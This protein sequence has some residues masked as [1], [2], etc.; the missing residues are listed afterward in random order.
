MSKQSQQQGGRR[1]GAQNQKSVQSSANDQ[2]YDG[3]DLLDSL[4][5]GFKA[6]IDDAAAQGRT[7]IGSVYINEEAFNELVYDHLESLNEANVGNE[8]EGESGDDNSN[9][10]DEEGSYK[11]VDASMN[12]NQGDNFTITQIYGY[13]GTLLAFKEGRSPTSQQMICK[14]ME[15]AEHRPLVKESKIVMIKNSLPFD[16]NFKL[17]GIRSTNV[18]MDQ[19]DGTHKRSTYHIPSDVV[20][21]MCVNSSIFTQGDDIDFELDTQQEEFAYTTNAEIEASVQFPEIGE[22]IGDKT[23]TSKEIE[24]YNAAK[25]VITNAQQG[26]VIRDSPLGRYIQANVASPKAATPW[27]EKLQNHMR[28]PQKEIETHIEDMKE[29]LATS[30]IGKMHG[31]TGTITRH[32]GKAWDYIPEGISEEEARHLLTTRQTVLVTVEHRVQAYLGE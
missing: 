9:D 13:E 8:I 6:V 5:V 7:N 27:D 23:P 1:R 31:M 26:W 14:E 21:P 16:L 25:E 11:R 17:D 19:F 28:L 3:M 12:K 18:Q 29:M 32:D 15:D 10:E 24:K 30:P 22:F 4:R 20:T 2:E